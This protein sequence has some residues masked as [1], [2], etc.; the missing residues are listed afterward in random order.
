MI[1]IGEV[2]ITTKLARVALLTLGL[3]FFNFAFSKNDK[4]T[5][6]QSFSWSLPW[7]LIGFIAITIIGSIFQY[8]GTL[9][10]IMENI[11]KLFS[12]VAMAAIGM[13]RIF[14]AIKIR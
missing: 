5:F 7:Y 9:V 6:D 3:I 12:P 10:D 4:T 2:A 14:R 1:E 11:G 8:P 13:N